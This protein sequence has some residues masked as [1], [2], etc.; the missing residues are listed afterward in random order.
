M[1]DSSE[2]PLWFFSLDFY[3]LDGV[4]ESLISVQEECG[5]DVNILLYL[6]WQ[7]SAGRHLSREDLEGIVQ[8]T[9]L[10]NKAVVVPLRNV[11]RFLKEK[12]NGLLYKRVESLREDV[13]S[14]ELDAEK[15]QQNY[16]FRISDETSMKTVI[17]NPTSVAEANF[18]AYE[19]L[20]NTVFPQNHRDHL[21]VTLRNQLNLTK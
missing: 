13:K 14:I 4:K 16:L 2:T 3:S 21:L 20:L 17:D 19:K 7:G 8:S 18:R 6:L 12:Q 10:W 11:R 9:D 5:A 1:T 15:I